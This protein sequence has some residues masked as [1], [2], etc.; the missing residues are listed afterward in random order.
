MG[1]E[2][3]EKEHSRIQQLADSAILVLTA[4]LMSVFGPPLAIAI[5][6]WTFNQISDLNIAVT[7]LNNKLDGAIALRLEY[8]DKALT[9]IDSRID[10]LEQW[11]YSA[12]GK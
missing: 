10:R 6:A 11:Y 1:K 9:G 4:R 8:H 3:G 5:L 7:T 2:E 12:K